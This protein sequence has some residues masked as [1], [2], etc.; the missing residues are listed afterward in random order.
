MKSSGHQSQVTYRLAEPELARA[1]WAASVAQRSTGITMVALSVLAVGLLAAGGLWRL[2]GVMAALI[3]LGM[4]VML[5]R[6]AARLSRLHPAVL[7]PV[8]LLFDDTGLCPALWPGQRGADGWVGWGAVA[9]WH[10]D[11]V[12]LSVTLAQPPALLL[13]PRAAFSDADYT[14]FKAL[15]TASD[16]DRPR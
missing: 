14:R 12:H 15:L 6:E 1:V 5:W 7:A 3:V 8:T 2:F 11:A 16:A 9:R 13:L 4:P 10:E